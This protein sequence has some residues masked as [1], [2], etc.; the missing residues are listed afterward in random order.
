M[1]II[2]GKL[3]IKLIILKL[4]QS[5]MQQQKVIVI[6]LIGMICY[7]EEIIQRIY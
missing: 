5:H 3:I 1:I 6:L 4:I 7:L 2:L